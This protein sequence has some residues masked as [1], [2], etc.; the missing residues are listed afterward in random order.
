MHADRINVM[1]GMTTGG[2]CMGYGRN[3]IK[4]GRS[5]AKRQSVR[6]AVQ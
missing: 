6:P 5:I 3:T 1:R 2:F 4:A